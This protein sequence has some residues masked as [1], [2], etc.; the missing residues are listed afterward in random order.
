MPGYDET[1]PQRMG[2]MSGGARG[3]CDPAAAGYGYGSGRGMAYD[4]GARG[5]GLGRG[6]RRGFRAGG[7]LPAYPPVYASSGTSE[8]GVLKVRAA[9]V[10]NTLDEINR[11]IDEL[12]KM[13]E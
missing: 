10:K 4:R 9:A 6:M 3:M 5:F 12:E 7:A 1:G 13:T 11:R 8:L 2:P